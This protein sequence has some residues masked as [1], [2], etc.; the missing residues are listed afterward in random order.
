MISGY[1]GQQYGVKN[2]MNVVG[3]R[4]TLR[5]FIVGDP[6]FW[7]KYAQDFYTN[8]PKWLASGEIKYKSDIAVGLENGPDKFVGMLRGENFGKTII[9]IAAE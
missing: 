7:P 9:Q 5:G 4:L 2:L 1:N 3:K 8:V 6:D